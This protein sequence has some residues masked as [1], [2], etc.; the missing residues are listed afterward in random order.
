MVFYNII[1]FVVM[2][3]FNCLLIWNLRKKLSSHKDKKKNTSPSS[4]SSKRPN[5]T[6]TLIILSFLSLIMTTPGTIMF[7]FFYD[8]FLINLDASMVFLIDDIMFLNHALL[9]F[10][11]FT[12]NRKFRAAL[13]DLGRSGENK[14]SKYTPN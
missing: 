1:P 7:V 2:I 13:F 8:G 3:T 4:S 6:V 9:F 11:S 5:L 10:V 12:T 14:A